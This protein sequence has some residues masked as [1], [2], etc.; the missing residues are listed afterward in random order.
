MGKKVS[1]NMLYLVGTALIVAGFILPMF[2]GLFGATSN[3]FDF[4][5][6]KFGMRTIGALLVIIGGACGL[7][8]NFVNVKNPSLKLL[9]VLVSIA[10]GVLLVIFYNDNSI[11][12]F[13]GKQLIKHAYI[14]FYMLICGW[15]VALIGACK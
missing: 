8:L 11:S 14:G 2:K 12:K 13:E 4:I 15:V 6:S 7:A 1:M 3:G 9:A 10:G 5:G